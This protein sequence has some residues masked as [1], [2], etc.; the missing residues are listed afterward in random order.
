M[1]QLHS[2][3]QAH[4]SDAEL[5]AATREHDAS[6]FA[7]LYERHAVAA[8][9]VARQFTVDEAEAHDAVAEAF[10]R[11]LAALVDGKGPDVSFRAYLFSVIRRLCFDA[12]ARRQ[13]F[14]F[15][16]DDALAALAED[17]D[18]EDLTFAALESSLVTTAFAQLP[19]RY[20]AVL[21]Y[22][23]VERM[24]T[25]AAGELLGL[26]ANG[27][28]ALAM[29]AREDLR[30]GYVQVHAT[31]SPAECE[32][33]VDSLGKYVRGSLSRRE[34]AKVDAHLEECDDCR[35]LV[36]ELSDVNAT[37]RAVLAPAILGTAGLG[38]LSGLGT[39]G[40]ADATLLA[41][42]LQVLQ[43][44][45]AAAGTAG[46]GKA[47]GTTSSST[48]TATA[49]TASASSS[50]GGAVA[51]AATSGLAGAA[52]GAGAAMGGVGAAATAGTAAGG[53]GAGVSG[54]ATGA[55]AALA[56][57]AGTVTT[58][59]GMVGVLALAVT[60]TVTAVNH[61]A[62]S[63]SDPTIAAGPAPLPAPAPSVAAVVTPGTA[64]TPGLPQPQDLP[65]TDLLTDLSESTDGLAEELVLGPAEALVESVA[66]APAAPIRPVTPKP[67]NPVPLP[68][69][70]TDAVI[71]VPVPPVD[72]AVIEV[73]APPII[74]DL[75]PELPAPGD[76]IP[77]PPAP[78]DPEPV[79][80]A[81]PD[82]GPSEPDPTDP[83]DPHPGEGGGP[84]WE[85]VCAVLNPPSWC[86]P[87]DSDDPTPTDPGTDPG[88]QPGDEPGTDPG[89]DPTHGSPGE[90]DPGTDPGI[91]PGDTPGTE[92]GDDPGTEPGDE[93]GTDP[94]D[95]PTHG[96]PGEPDPVPGTGDGDDQGEDGDDDEQGTSPGAGG[97]GIEDLIQDP[98]SGTG[99][100]PGA[101]TTPNP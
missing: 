45:G 80:P 42:G 30:R 9:R 96:S 26:T 97:V 12:S 63:A 4:A 98:G 36:A 50:A 16:S 61:V 94:G 51:G 83:Q 41:T 35:L 65:G 101:G 53:V 100:N 47:A 43:R 58:L 79:Q 64:T 14:E 7:V 32:P 17:H 3:W 62:A 55:V 92:P 29:R 22:L 37:L 89:D 5:I 34:Q 74:E 2:D 69:P 66:P 76:P 54:A 11:C 21:W 91:D 33:F 85:L 77:G 10:T 20:Q 78:I 18:T 8:L 67:A 24:S 25:A 49:A 72:D 90:P 6:S 44:A 70:P 86:P 82:P 28:S 56:T 1:T 81:I 57:G 59:V 88:T 60:G 39:I 95:D 13:R 99:P 46:A 73:P 19:E 68:A 84:I 71:D 40:G 93:P 75:I 23:E 15:D 38:A 31:T 48:S 87:A 52:S 27:V